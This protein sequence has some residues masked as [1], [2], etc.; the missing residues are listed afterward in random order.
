MDIKIQTKR[1]S[2]AMKKSTR[3]QYKPIKELL[4]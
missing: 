4:N 2:L 1:H 3:F